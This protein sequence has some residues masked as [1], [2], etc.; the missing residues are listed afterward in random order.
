MTS[1]AALEG[2]AFPGAAVPVALG[3][4][5]FYIPHQ[6]DEAI[7]MAG[8]ILQHK[9]AGRQVFVVLLTDGGNDALREVMNQDVCRLG[10]ACPAPGG[11]HGLRWAEDGDDVV[12][13]R[14]AEFLRSVGH[15]GVDRVFTTGL[16][17]TP[18]GDPADAP[19]TPRYDAFVARVE[20]VVRSFARRHP[21]ASHRFVAGWLDGN[22]THKACSDAAFNVRDEI[23]D[24]GFNHVYTYAKD[25][26]G[27]RA[28]SSTVL[29]LP[30]RWMAAKRRAIASYRVWDPANGF[31]ALG[32]HS[33]PPWLD[34][35]A[36]DPREFQYRLPASYVKGP[37][38]RAVPVPGPRGAPTAPPLG[39]AA[40]PSDPSPPVPVPLPS[41]SVDCCAP[42]SM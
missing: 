23:E 38:G 33:V 10:P 6:D 42:T 24:L 41:A 12:R 35:A 36:T 1:V 39:Q 21:H 9:A 28:R 22:L 27:E 25:P 34:N 18:Y 17:D 29:H 32:Y 8:T 4:A 19:G 2:L 14:T 16:H 20:A 11:R 13:G 7:G 40:A 37:V 5:I 31:Y 15:L 26:V 30:Q 3:P